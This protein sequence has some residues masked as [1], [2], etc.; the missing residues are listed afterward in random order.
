MKIQKT[1]NKKNLNWFSYQSKLHLKLEQTN[2][3]RQKKMK[4]F[5]KKI[6]FIVV[7]IKK[8]NAKII[9]NRGIFPT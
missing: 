5:S 3:I 1:K 2:G 6:I 9:V 4:R 8:K 7:L